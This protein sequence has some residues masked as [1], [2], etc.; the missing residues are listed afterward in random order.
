MGGWEVGSRLRTGGGNATRAGRERE[1]ARLTTW[2]KAADETN[3]DA[4][5]AETGE[6]RGV[7]KRW[8]HLGVADGGPGRV[9]APA[10]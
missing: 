6:A 1:A 10:Y 4:N 5:E 9:W 8:D 2:A 3:G 7:S